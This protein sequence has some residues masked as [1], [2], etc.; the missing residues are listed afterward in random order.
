MRQR[1]RCFAGRDPDAYLWGCRGVIHV[2]ANVGHEAHEYGDHG[3]RVLWIEPI[4]DV[5]E[6]LVERIAEFP[7]QT[8]IRALVTETTGKDYDFKI[9]NNGGGSSSIFDMEKTSDIWP[10][11]RFERV[12]RLRSHSLTDL[13]RDRG[14]DVSLYDCLVMDTQ[15][16][17]LLVLRGAEPLLRH[18]KYIKT[19]AADFEAYA[20]CAKLKDISDF[21]AERGFKEFS[22]HQMAS[23]P[24]GGAYFEL[25]F[26]RE[27]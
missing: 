13:C 22:R 23:H 27:R 26:K 14:V 2:G 15:G 20:G 12:I 4:P 19:E 8:A 3:V 6:A 24:D 10:E 1:V 9:A 18:F 5:Y 11:V 21:L 25:L 16:S 7:G 17:E